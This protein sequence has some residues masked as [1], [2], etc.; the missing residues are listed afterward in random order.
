[1]NSRICAKFIACSDRRPPCS[2][3]KLL[4]EVPP[5]KSPWSI[6]AT[7]KPAKRRIP[8]GNRAIEAGADHDQIEASIRQAA[9][10]AHHPKA[11]VR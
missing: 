10:I 3:L 4:N 1:M 7:D 11:I 9:E 2:V 8:R 6:S 5:P